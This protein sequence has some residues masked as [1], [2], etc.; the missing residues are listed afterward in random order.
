MVVFP[1][2]QP[3]R[4]VG[5]EG[6]GGGGAVRVS[7]SFPLR[8]ACGSAPSARGFA[9]GALT[10]PPVSCSGQSLF[11]RRLTHEFPRGPET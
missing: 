8:P 6:Q 1:Q 11:S 3:F 9:F 2:V 10:R 7:A 5:R 4:N